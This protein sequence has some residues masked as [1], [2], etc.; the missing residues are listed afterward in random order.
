MRSGRFVLQIDGRQ[1]VDFINRCV[2]GGGGLLSK[3]V[4]GC[5][6]NS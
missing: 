3:L 6:L 1:E 4:G 5:L 2:C